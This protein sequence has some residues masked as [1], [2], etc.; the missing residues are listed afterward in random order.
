MSDGG[1]VCSPANLYFHFIL[2]L[3]KPSCAFDASS[4]VHHGHFEENHPRVFSWLHRCDQCLRGNRS[5]E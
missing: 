2:P 5:C 1:S 3:L 4:G